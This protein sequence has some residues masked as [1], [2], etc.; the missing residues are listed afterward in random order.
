MAGSVPDSEENNAFFGRPPNASRDGAFPQVRWVAAAESG[1]G[2][3]TGA[4]FGPYTA[5]EQAL[6]LDLLPGQVLHDGTYLA[7][8][9][10][11]RNRDGPA[12]TVRIRWR[13][14]WHRG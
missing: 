2:V 4:A 11:A 10:P 6:A 13:G 9:N 1:T 7:R 3:L 12:V 8:L 14:W 5:G